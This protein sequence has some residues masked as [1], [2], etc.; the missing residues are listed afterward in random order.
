MS[1]TQLKEQASRL[2]A[3]ERLDLAAFLDE[4]DAMNV[5]SFQETV[6]LR[7]QAMD[8]GNKVTQQELEDLNRQTAGI[9]VLREG[10]SRT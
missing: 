8:R 5:R 6:D 7:M 10:R 2:S 4:L 9:D 1:L 3:D